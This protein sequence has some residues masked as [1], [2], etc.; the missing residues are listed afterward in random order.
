MKNLTKI[1][2]ILIGFT[3]LGCIGSAIAPS[4]QAQPAYGSY[5]GV[6]A[7]FGFS[8]GDTALGETSKTSALVGVRY[9]F[10]EFPIS[11]RTQVLIGSSTAVVPTIS[12]DV[13]IN[14]DTD[15]YIG[16]GISL[17]NTVDATPIGNKTTFVVQPGIDY[18]L[19]NSNLVLFG[20]VIFALDAYRNTSGNSATSLQTGLGLRF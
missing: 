5:V 15:V 9:K 20:N 19:P 16:A 6:G 8:S 14:F 13:P 3:A 11:V 10:L 18:T 12:F 4:A 17:A 2:K 7:S 1:A